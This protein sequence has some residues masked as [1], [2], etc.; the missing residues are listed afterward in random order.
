MGRSN[1]LENLFRPVAVGFEE[2]GVFG[3]FDVHVVGGDH[4][5]Q[6]GAA[7]LGGE[8]LRETFLDDFE[9]DV[10]GDRRARRSAEERGDGARGIGDDLGA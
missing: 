7:G 10:D 2:G 1:E 4:G 6:A 3:E 5:F 8:Q 9:D